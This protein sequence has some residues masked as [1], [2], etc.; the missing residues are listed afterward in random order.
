MRWLVVAIA[1]LASAG[2]MAVG[3]SMNFA[4]GS[5]FGRTA[6]ESY[7]Y[8]AAFGFADILKVAAP[9]VVAKSL[10]NR[11]WG[12]AVVGLLLWGTFTVCSAVSAIGFSSANR[13]FAI[14]SRTVQAALNQSR[15]LSLETDQS[16]LRRLRDRIASPELGR[17][18]RIQLAAAAQRLEA[19]IAASR[20]KLEDASPV[21]S[22]PNPQAHTLAK[23]TGAG[24]DKIEVGLVL[25][26]A[27]LVEM[28][29][30]G[31]F[32]TMNLAKV[33]QPSKV[34]EGSPPEKTSRKQPPAL[35]RASPPL[36]PEPQ[37][38]RLIHSA[39]APLPMA[40]DLERFLDRHAHRDDRTAVGSSEL[41][42]RYNCSLQQRGLPETSQRRLGDAMRAL[43]H[44]NK[45]RLAD[46]RIHYQGLAWRE[47]DSGVKPR[48]ERQVQAVAP[49]RRMNGAD[50][51]NGVLAGGRAATLSS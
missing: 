40:I 20:G 47:P 44:H 36:S 14:D 35:G 38:P 22:T 5:S 49:S 37:R 1:G 13:T 23:L 21:V 39:V 9:I 29:G 26:V 42:A 3:V 33:P 19:A 10:G 41:L 12:A 11:N 7:A 31:P 18:E 34:P 25:L 27:L 4:F 2:L 8:G 51:K 48:R 16:E 15:L 43:G 24:I 46:G 28:G 17:G 45:P 30:L 32:I 6:L 50:G